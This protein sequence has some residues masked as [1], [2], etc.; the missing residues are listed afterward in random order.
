MEC[1]VYNWGRAPVW[2][3]GMVSVRALGDQF[4]SYPRLPVTCLICKQETTHNNLSQH[5]NSKACGSH[6]WHVWAYSFARNHDKM[7]PEDVIR[8]L[9]EAGITPDDIGQHRG[10]YQLARYGD[11]GRYEYGNCRFIT[12]EENLRERKCSP[13][14]GKYVRTEEWKKNLSKIRTKQWK[15]GVYANR[16]PRS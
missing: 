3:V 16:K 5:Q 14:N 12:M 6:P 11:K 2:L 1:P 13:M 9:N 8:L 15:D 10:D 7:P 4:M